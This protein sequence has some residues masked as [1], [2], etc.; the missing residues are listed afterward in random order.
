MIKRQ[1]TIVAKPKSSRAFG[2]VI[3]MRQPIDVVVVAPIRLV[4]DADGVAE[5]GRNSIGSIYVF[6][7][8]TSIRGPQ[9]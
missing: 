7:A 6:R 8:K 9:R 4:D 2:H 5:I 1:F 3:A